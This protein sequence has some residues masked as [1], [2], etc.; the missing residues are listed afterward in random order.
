MAL[1]RNAGGGAAG[2]LA[3]TAP[4][5]LAAAGGVRGGINAHDP[6]L[7]KTLTTLCLVLKT[8][9]ALLFRAYS[10][11][12]VIPGEKVSSR[13]SHDCYTQLL[14]QLN[15]ILSKAVLI[16]EWRSWIIDSTVNTSTHVLCKRT[17][18]SFIDF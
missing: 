6:G 15:Y 7:G 5:A 3:A 12:P 16:C 13:I 14:D 10:I 17:I 2:G 4:C 18:N 11:F 9:G 1:P 8:R